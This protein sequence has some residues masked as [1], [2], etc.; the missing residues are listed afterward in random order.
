MKTLTSYAKISLSP[1][2]LALSLIPFRSARQWISIRRP[3]QVSPF[4]RDTLFAGVSPLIITLRSHR[5]SKSCPRQVGK[6]ARNIPNSGPF[7]SQR[8]PTKPLNIN[9]PAS[10]RQP[11]CLRRLSCDL[12][13]RLLPLFRAIKYQQAA[14]LRSYRFPERRHLLSP[15]P[16]AF[17]LPTNGSQHAA[18]LSLVHSPE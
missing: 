5:I 12:S 14:Q 6:F 17:T 8:R 18:Q 7:S 9:T 2:V 15:S 1:S 13:L 10:P 3:V 4:A 16:F 11:I